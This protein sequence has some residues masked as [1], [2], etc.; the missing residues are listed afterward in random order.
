ME[1]KAMTQGTGWAVKVWFA[2][3]KG[4]RVVATFTNEAD[5]RREA[6]AYGSDSR[7]IWIVKP[8]GTE[9]DVKGK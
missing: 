4:P 7:G 3:S 8:D 6:R 1:D 9:I 5:A 2:V